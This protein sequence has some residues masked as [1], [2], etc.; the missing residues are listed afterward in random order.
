M[1]A[2][3]RASNRSGGVLPGFTQMR[4]TWSAKHDAYYVRVLPGEYYVTKMPEFSVT[5]LGSCVSACIS[6]PT[7]GIGGMNHFMLP[8]GRGGLDDEHCLDLSTRY[9][10]SAMEHMIND[11][12][13]YGGSRENLEVKLFGGA[14][15][16]AGMSDVGEGNIEFVREYLAA[17]EINITSE[18][19]G[20]DYPRKVM[21]FPTTGKAFMKRI[22]ITR[23]SSVLE[24][25]RSYQKTLQKK[26]IA[27]EIELF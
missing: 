1:N 5:V 19:L 17:E 26:P 2:V 24:Q 15:V 7:V 10:A 11:I 23:G 22:P 21:Y 20:G 4:R 3:Q 14:Q 13:K 12:L 16:M 6:D 9:G 27:G 8:G 25:E 18:D